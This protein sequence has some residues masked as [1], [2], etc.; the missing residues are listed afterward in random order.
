MCQQG[1]INKTNV[2]RRPAVRRVAA[3]LNFK[4]KTATAPKRKGIVFFFFFV[5]LPQ[6]ATVIVATHAGLFRRIQ[7]LVNDCL[8]AKMPCCQ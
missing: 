5:L 7:V 2:C 3:S 1:L 8:A 4:T 6:M